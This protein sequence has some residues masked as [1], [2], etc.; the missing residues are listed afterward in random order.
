MSGRLV[1]VDTP[2]LSEI[3]QAL[4]DNTEVMKRTLRILIRSENRENREL[5]LPSDKVYKRIAF[6]Q[7]TYDHFLSETN[8]FLGSIP[9]NVASYIQNNPIS[10]KT[11]EKEVQKWFKDVTTCL[12]SGQIVFRETNNTPYLNGY[13][14]DFSIFNINDIPN[15]SYTVIA[16]QTILELKKH[17]RTIGFSDEEKGQL[18]DY[19]HILIEQQLLRRLFAVFLSDGIFLYVMA[20]DRNTNRHQECQTDFLTGIRLIHTLIYQNSGYTKICESTIIDFTKQISS[21]RTTMVKI[22]LKEF[23]GKGSSARVYKIDWECEPAAIK[24]SSNNLGYEANILKELSVH[25]FTNVPIILAN[26][27]NN[28]V[29]KPVCE[30]FNNNLNNFQAQHYM[31]L[32]NLLKRIHSFRVFHRDIRPSNIML[33]TENNLLVLVDWGSA[34]HNPSDAPILYE[35]TTTYASPSILDNNFGNYIPKPSD[36]LHSFVRTVY[37]MRNPLKKPH[38]ASSSA[39]AIKDYWNNELDGR[40]LWKEMTNAAENNQVDL[41]EKICD[42]FET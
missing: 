24:M 12:S 29:I 20:F 2:I 3:M 41:L 38:L 34:V 22:R 18:M 9:G 15:D 30:Y 11:T 14:P 4:K 7:V 5:K 16:V 35:G 27:N 10:E 6:E 37:I 39:Q 17:K 40:A 36:D 13:K 8:S 23:L 21:T 25:N 28:L 19:L 42:I 26:N 32:L 33:D 1:S 31:D